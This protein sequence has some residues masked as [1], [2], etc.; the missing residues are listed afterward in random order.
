VEET[1]VVNISLALVVPAR[2]SKTPRFLTDLRSFDQL[3]LDQFG[4]EY[5][6]ADGPRRHKPLKSQTRSSPPGRDAS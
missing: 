6:Y 4:Q 3:A 1:H 2:T 5:A